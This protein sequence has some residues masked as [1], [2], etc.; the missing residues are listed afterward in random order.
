[1]QSSAR[2]PHKYAVIF[3]GSKNMNAQ[4][5]NLGSLFSFMHALKYYAFAIFKH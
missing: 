4:R 1:M 2:L 3:L 5:L